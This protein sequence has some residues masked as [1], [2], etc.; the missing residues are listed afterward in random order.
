MNHIPT[1]QS[2]VNS[3]FLYPNEGDCNDGCEWR[4]DPWWMVDADQLT[5]R[6]DSQPFICEGSID[7][8]VPLDRS[9]RDQTVKINVMIDAP[10]GLIVDVYSIDGIEIEGRQF[11]TNGGW[12]QMSLITKTTLA[13]N[14]SVE[15]VVSG[16]GDSWINPLW[17]TG[18]GDKLFDH[19]GI[20][21]H[22]VELRPM[23]A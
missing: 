23:V 22:W 12:Q 14:L 8:T 7:F 2:A 5:N 20:R 1:M 17:I 21:I 6:P 18:R 9:S 3:H 10:A 4:P 11:I 13:D 16:G 15:I 19:D